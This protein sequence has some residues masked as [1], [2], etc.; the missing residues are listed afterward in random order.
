LR[1]DD[2]TNLL[3]AVLQGTKSLATDA[4]PTGAAM[5][6]FS[7][8]LSDQQIATGST[9]IRN[10]WANSAPVLSAA[11]AASARHDLEQMAE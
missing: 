3:R 11:E 1:S 2:P 4:S 9:Y 8:K 10:E 5:P 7:W 6:A